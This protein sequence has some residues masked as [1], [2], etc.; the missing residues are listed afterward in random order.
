MGGVVVGKALLPA[1]L[2]L[3]LLRILIALRQEFPV[4]WTPELFCASLPAESDCVSTGVE[5]GIFR[6][7]VSKISKRV[8]LSAFYQ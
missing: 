1:P 2:L 4:I 3:G 7:L 6:R 5:I 8:V